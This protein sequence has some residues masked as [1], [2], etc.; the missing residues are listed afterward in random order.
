MGSDGV[1]VVWY[2]GVSVGGGG[3]GGRLHGR[4]SIEG[5]DIFPL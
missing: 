4:A 1:R 3:G 2:G 5:D